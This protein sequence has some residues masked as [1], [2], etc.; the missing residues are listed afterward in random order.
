M[1]RLY[2]VGMDVHKE[3]IDVLIFRDPGRQPYLERRIPNREQTVRKL[4]GKLLSHGSVIACYE[5]G[6]MGFELQRLLEGMGITSIVTAPGKVP[7][8]T[9]D[10]V[11]TDRRDARRLAEQLRAGTLEAIHIPSREDEAVRDYLRAREDV[12]GE[13]VKAKQRLQKYLLR[14]GYVYESVRYWTLRHDRWLRGLEFD[15][16]LL[17][18][19]FDQY[20]YRIQ[21][22]REQLR[23]MDKRIE[24]IALSEEYA[25]RVKKLR[26]LKGIDYMTALSIVC[27]VGDFKRFGHAESFMSFL[28]LVPQERSSGEKRRQGGITK[29]GNTHIRKLLIESSWHYRYKSLP[30]KRLTERRRGQP[31]EIIAYADRAMRR[32]QGKYF[33]LLLKG[34]R[35]QVAVTAV[36]RELAG[37][38]WGLMVGQTV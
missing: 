15:K 36:A 21:E 33:H 5:A 17:K 23:C 10:R 28:G 19:T 31:S 34:K 9:T 20:Y 11:K 16:P 25:C 12:R 22:L 2:Y 1:V 35:P 4:F 18:E 29:S 6:C 30:S 27:E 24:E 13:Q 37:F 32:L 26:C 3:T 38:V 8:R 7:R 14:H